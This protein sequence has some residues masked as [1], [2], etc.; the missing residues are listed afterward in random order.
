MPNINTFIFLLSLLTGCQSQSKTDSPNR[1]PTASPTINTMVPSTSSP[2]K[3]P[4]DP[5]LPSKNETAWSHCYLS[6]STCDGD[7]LH[8]LSTQH[9]RAI[10]EIC[11]RHSKLIVGIHSVTFT[12]DVTLGPYG[13]TKK[14][15]ISCFS[16]RSGECITQIKVAHVGTGMFG[17][18]FT[19][20]N[21]FT[22]QMYGSAADVTKT[23]DEKNTIITAPYG[24]LTQISAWDDVCGGYCNWMG[25]SWTHDDAIIKNIQFGFAET[26]APSLSPTSSPS[27]P[28]MPPSLA[29]AVSPTESTSAPTTGAPSTKTVPPTKQPSQSPTI[30]TTVWS[31]CY[32]AWRPC[33]GDTRYSIHTTHNGAI[34]G[35]CLRH[36]EVI[37][38]IHS[39]T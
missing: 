19:A 24:C 31:S 35:I 17:L 33:V 13:G 34:T 7:T 4:S 15:N 36:S 14:G 22:S 16:V 1:F 8:T 20:S 38:G 11:L 28:T 39:V 32:L 30:D 3:H 29:P 6:W 27:Q 2:T 10:T 37:N 25:Y 26:P 12:D 9:N 21:N 5:S 23:Y 18:Q